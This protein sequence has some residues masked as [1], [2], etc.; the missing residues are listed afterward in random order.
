MSLNSA[1]VDRARIIRRVAAPVKVEGRTQ[2]TDM[3]GEWFRARL[4]LRRDSKR[5]DPGTRSSA[6]RTPVLM[7]GVRDLR[8]SQVDFRLGD[9]IEVSSTE[10]GD[11][12]YEV[13]SAPEPMRKKKRLLG[14]ELPLRRIQED[15]AN[16]IQPELP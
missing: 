16:L 7:C 15:P 13:A 14:F 9:R 3:T 12:L 1:L 4:E 10:L 5:R 11:A 2:F 6:V 8:G